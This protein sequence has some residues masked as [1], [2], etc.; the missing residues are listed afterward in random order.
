MEIYIAIMLII[1]FFGVFTDREIID[2]QD[3]AIVNRKFFLIGFSF[4]LFL[5]SAL[6]FN[7]GTDYELYEY[8]YQLAGEKELELGFLYSNAT[9]LSRFFELPYQ[10]FIALNSFLFIIIIYFY[11]RTHSSYYYIS[12]ITLLGTY[13]YFTSFNTFRQMTAAAF[14]LLSFLLFFHFRKKI[15]SLLLFLVAVGFHK[16]TVMYAPIF[17]LGFFKMSKKVYIFL[18]ICCL[19]AFFFL[20]ESVKVY[21]FD[22]LLNQSSFFKEKYVDSEFIEGATRGLTNKVFFLF[23]FVMILKL[24]LHDSFQQEQSWIERTFI[25][26]LL[27]Q[28]FLPYSNI[29]ERMSILFELLAICL[30]PRFIETFQYRWL[31]NL[32][33]AGVITVFIV[34]TVY[35]LLLNGDGVVPYKSIIGNVILF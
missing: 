17:L 12:L 20:P 7:I 9:E 11:I 22:L 32:V 21:F 4:I 13:M 15:F 33:K 28:S 35:V 27:I 31:K 2:Y 26:Y 3:L 5:I 29:T 23:Y 16:S 24:V 30:V 8:I 18:L 25:F 34:R 19:G 6:R 1:V 10:Y 14:I